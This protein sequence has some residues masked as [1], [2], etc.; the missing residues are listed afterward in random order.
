MGIIF[1]DIANDALKDIY[2]IRVEDTALV[3][4]NHLQGYFMRKGLLVAALLGQ[5]IIDISNAYYLAI[6]AQLFT[7]DAFWIATAIIALMVMQA[8]IVSILKN[9]RGIDTNLLN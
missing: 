1:D 3:G 4:A 5:S 2:E 8:N 7:L 6:N 9:I